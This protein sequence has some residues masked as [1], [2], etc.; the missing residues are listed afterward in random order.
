[1]TESDKTFGQTGFLGVCVTSMGGCYSV[2]LTSPYVTLRCSS[3]D[4]GYNSVNMLSWPVAADF[5]ACSKFA[6]VRKCSLGHSA[7]V[8]VSRRHPS[9]SVWLIF[10]QSTFLS[11]AVGWWLTDTDA[12]C[13]SLVKCGHK[14]KDGSSYRVSFPGIYRLHM[15]AVIDFIRCN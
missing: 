14:T 8:G 6:C 7:S 3:V 13:R 5:Y 1:M 15:L 10:G 2:R 11:D 12:A 4:K 9:A